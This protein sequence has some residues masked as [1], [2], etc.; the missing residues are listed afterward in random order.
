MHMSTFCGP[1]FI[2]VVVG[3]TNTIILKIAGGVRLVAKMASDLIQ[4]LFKK[5][6]VD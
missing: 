6:V 4:K 3:A 5:I 2:V 1:T